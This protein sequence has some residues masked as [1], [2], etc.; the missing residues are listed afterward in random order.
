VSSSSEEEVPDGD[1]EDD[2]EDL[3][4]EREP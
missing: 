3:S 2:S 1:F 4:E